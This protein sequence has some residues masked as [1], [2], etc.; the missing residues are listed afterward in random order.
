MIR[1][2]PLW[3]DFSQ[4]GTILCRSGERGSDSIIHTGVRWRPF[5]LQGYKKQG[6]N[7]TAGA[8]I[9]SCGFGRNMI[10]FATIPASRHSRNLI[11]MR[12][13]CA[14]VDAL[15]AVHRFGEEIIRVV[16]PGTE[17]VRQVALHCPTGLTTGQLLC[18]QNVASC[19]VCAWE[20][21]GSDTDTEKRNPRECKTEPEVVATDRLLRTQP[22]QDF[23]GKT[24][25]RKTE[26]IGKEEG[27]TAKTAAGPGE[28]ERGA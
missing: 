16:L 7:K 3:A 9:V 12:T 14:T 10:L 26:P 28:A 22:T 2:G 20:K 6:F 15:F 11:C 27:S 5:T 24:R 21:Q 25:K 23:S 1:A 18:F 17:K 8:F 19:R 13:K 4:G